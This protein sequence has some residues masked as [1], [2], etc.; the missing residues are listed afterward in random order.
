M[1]TTILSF[2]SK[3]PSR[4]EITVPRPFEKI[5]EF[6]QDKI[7][8]IFSHFLFIHSLEM[9]LLSKNDLNPNKVGLT[10]GAYRDFDGKPW[11]LPIVG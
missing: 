7:F 9:K 6:P 3:T 5:P 10:V 1:I 2:V 8:S 11:I 4:K